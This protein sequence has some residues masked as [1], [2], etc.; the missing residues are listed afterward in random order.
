[1]DVL[2]KFP[3]SAWRVV[4]R[5]YSADYNVYCGLTAVALCVPRELA[6]MIKAAPAMLAV[7]RRIVEYARSQTRSEPLADI[8]RDAVTV[9]D[10]AEGR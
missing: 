1:M 10:S 4:P 6:P 9:L 8:A 7:V 3:A 5:K 2:E